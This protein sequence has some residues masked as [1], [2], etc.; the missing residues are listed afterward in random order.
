LNLNDVKSY[1]VLL[2]Q[3]IRIHAVL[4]ML[5]IDIFDNN[6][7]TLMYSSFRTDHHACC[8]LYFFITS[9]WILVTNTIKSVYFL[10]LY[11]VLWN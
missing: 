5:S 11:V 1:L 7:N 6:I 2:L 8:T 4:F 10:W 3:Q 9:L